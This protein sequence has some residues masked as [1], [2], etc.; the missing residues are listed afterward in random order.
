[1][2]GVQTCA[3]PNWSIK[4]RI[5]YIPDPLCWKEVQTNLRHLSI[6]RSNQTNNY[7]KTLFRNKKLFFNPKYGMLGLIA[8]PYW[9]FVKWLFPIIEFSGMMYAIILAFFG[10]INWTFFIL[11]ITFL[12]CFA[13]SYS[14]CAILYEELTF[15]EYKNKKE[16]LMLFFTLLIEPLIYHPFNV[17]C[18]IRGNISYLIK[19]SVR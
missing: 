18:A 16:L 15:Q 9:F 6:Q 17:Y 14:T 4:H 8:Y 5:A 2:T 7:I 3:L 13:I 12:Y 19:R 10:I 11:I 1:M